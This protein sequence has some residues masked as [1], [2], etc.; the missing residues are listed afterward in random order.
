MVIAGMDENTWCCIMSPN[1]LV[2]TCQGSRDW[3]G[4]DRNVAT[5][6]LKAQSRSSRAVQSSSAA[7][8]RLWLITRRVP[9]CLHCSTTSPGTATSLLAP[10]CYSPIC[11][12]TS[13]PPLLVPAVGRASPASSS[14]RSRRPPG[15]LR[16]TTLCL[17]AQAKSFCWSERMGELL[18]CGMPGYAPSLCCGTREARVRERG[19]QAERGSGSG[20]PL[21]TRTTRHLFTR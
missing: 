1:K 6:R 5:S 15:L 19:G 12:R 11:T 14:S 10:L 13:V 21:I 16:G 20:A 17:A 2:P 9:G 8:S 4:P 18:E 3:E 7:L